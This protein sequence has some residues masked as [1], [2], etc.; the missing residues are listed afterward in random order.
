METGNMNAMTIASTNSEA[1]SFIDDVAPFLSNPELNLEKFANDGGCLVVEIDQYDVDRL[2]PII[3]LFLGRLIATL[4]KKACV[5]ATGRLPNK[6]VIIIDEIAAAGAVPGIGGA[7]HTGREGNLCFVAGAQSISQLP[8]IYGGHADLVLS[9]FQT[10]IALGGGLD[11]ATAEYFS[12]RSGVATIAIPTFLQDLNDQ[13]GDTATARTWQM[14]PRPV[15]LPSDIASPNRH[16]LLGHPA[17]VILGDGSIPPFQVYLS[18]AY[19]NGSLARLME[20]VDV[21]TTDDDLRKHPLRA[22]PLTVETMVDTES[23]FPFSDTTGWSRERIRQ[24]LDD[25]M[26]KIEWSNTTG[27]A[28]KWWS[29]FQLENRQKL[30][31]ILRLAEELA[32]RNATVTEFFLA[33]VYSNT[34]SIQANLLYLDYTRL[35]KEHDRTRKEQA[36]ANS[37]SN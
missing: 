5:S 18:A 2:R 12:R 3:T 23:Q 7:L 6:T 16:P 28:R 29:E 20:Q 36:R 34:D 21:Q 35:K 10:Q 8:A 32:S 14:A 11:P 22:E 13:D 4:Q 37:E 27:S 25:V 33:Y 17:T 15:L 30:S 9:G 24:R 31:L 19:E 26:Q 1:T